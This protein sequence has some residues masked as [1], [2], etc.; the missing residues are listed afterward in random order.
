VTLAK[1]FA[2]NLK[3]VNTDPPVLPSSCG[4][5]SHT[6]PLKATV[7]EANPPSAEGKKLMISGEALAAIFR[8]RA[9]FAC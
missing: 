8:C 4:E 2:T 6:N 5:E 7:G 3:F 1:A 9:K